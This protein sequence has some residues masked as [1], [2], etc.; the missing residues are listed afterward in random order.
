MLFA[1]DLQPVALKFGEAKWAPA[2]LFLKDGHT[3]LSGDV[4]DLSKYAQLGVYTTLDTAKSAAQEF[5]NE[6]YPISMYE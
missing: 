4:V 6:T 5:I 1:S 2:I 3:Y